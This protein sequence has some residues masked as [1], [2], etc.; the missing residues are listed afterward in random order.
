MRQSFSPGFCFK[1]RRPNYELDDLI[2]GGYSS[3]AVTACDSRKPAASEQGRNTRPPNKWF[4]YTHQK[5]AGNFSVIHLLWW[6]VLSS[7]LNGWPG[8]AGTADLMHPTAQSMRP[9]IGGY[10]F[11]KGLRHVTK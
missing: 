5:G 11:F 4:F 3:V 1:T 2:D 10:P 6:S 9:L 7:P 8:L